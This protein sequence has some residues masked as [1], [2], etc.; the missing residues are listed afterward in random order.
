MAASRHLP[1]SRSYTGMLADFALD[2]P[3]RHVDA[4]DGVVQH[5]AVAPVGVDVHHVP[6]V[7]DVG[8]VAALEQAVVFHR[9]TTGWGAA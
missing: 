1:P 9:L 2:V 6:Q 4:A 3:Q 8:R 5:R 7:F